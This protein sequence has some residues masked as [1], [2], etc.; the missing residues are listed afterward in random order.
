M[1]VSGSAAAYCRIGFAVGESEQAN[2][3][4]F[5]AGRGL[6]EGDS[7]YAIGGNVCWRIRFWSSVFG[8]IWFPLAVPLRV[9]SAWVIARLQSEGAVV[10]DW[11]MVAEVEGDEG[12]VI[13]VEIHSGGGDLRNDQVG[14]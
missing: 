2:L 1:Y 3:E 13:P 10:L 6:L 5:S 12:G 14:G 11:I 7:D 9:G 4:T 8:R